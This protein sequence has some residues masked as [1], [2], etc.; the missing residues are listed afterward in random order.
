M[1]VERVSAGGSHW[2]RLP[3]YLHQILKTPKFFYKIEK[4]PFLSYCTEVIKKLN[5]TRFWKM[6]GRN[7]AC[8]R[9]VEKEAI[10]YFRFLMSMG[11]K[12]DWV[13]GGK[14]NNKRKTYTMHW[15][16]ES[17]QEIL[18]WAV[19]ESPHACTTVHV[20]WIFLLSGVYCNGAHS[21]WCNSL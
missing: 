4:S 16:R 21:C 11:G 10:L 9:F 17:A 18:R 1:C 14:K 7:L 8:R 6:E 19:S 5:G 13:C 2:V 20:L 15:A 12:P 3:G